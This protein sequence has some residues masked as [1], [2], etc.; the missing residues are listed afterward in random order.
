MKFKRIFSAFLAVALICSASSSASVLGTSF[1]NGYSIPIASETYFCNNTFLSDQSGVGL[2]TEN[3]I[4]YT[5]NPNVTPVVGYGKTV[6]GNLTKTLNEGNRLISEGKD[7]VGGINADYF[8]FQTGVPM[9]NLVV[10]GEVITKDSSAK[11]GFGV[12]ENGNGFMGES[13]ITATLIRNDNRT[14]NIECI[15]KYRQ[16]YAMY[17]LNSKFSDQTHNNT[18]GFDIII[19]PET[20]ELKIGETIKG[21]VTYALCYNGSIK[22]PEGALVL[23][24]D[25]NAPMFNDIADIAV[26]DEVEI[27][28]DAPT[29]PRW[30]TA[31]FGMGSTGE[32][33]LSGGVVTPG[34]AAGA[35]PR[36]AIGITSDGNIILY[37]IDGRQSG[38]SYGVKLSTLAERMKELGCVEAIN[39]DGGGSTTIVG[40]L[41]GDTS[42]TLL[43]KPSDGSSRAVSTSIFLQNNLSATGKIGQIQIYPAEASYVLKGS[44]VTL[45]AKGVDTGF[46]PLDISGKVSYS[47]QSGKESTITSGGVFKARDSGSVSVI[48]S[49]DGVS[50]THEVFCVESPTAI[51]VKDSNGNALSTLRVS[52]NSSLDLSAVASYG[53]HTLEAN[54]DCFNWSV[55][56][57]I[58]SID[59]NGVF[60]ASNTIG[61]SGV[62]T[63]SAGDTICEIPTFITVDGGEDEELLYS[64]IDAEIS[65]G[66]LSGTIENEYSVD[67]QYSKLKITADG[68]ALSPEYDGYSFSVALPENTEKVRITATNDLEYT[69]VWSKTQ[70]IGK[71]YENPFVDTDGNWAK[72]I[73]S[74]MY[75]KGLVSGEMTDKGLCYNP[76]KEM[77]RAEF[78]VLICNYLKIDP[79]SY[80]SITLPYADLGEIPAWSLNH[81]KALYSLGILKG[82]GEGANGIYAD[83]KTGVSRAEAVTII[84]R[85]LPNGLKKTEVS[86]IDIEDI[87]SWALDGFKILMADKTVSGYEDGSLKPLKKLTKAEA[88]KLLY[89][90]Y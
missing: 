26:G 74:Y 68:E 42:L 54:D 50:A 16:P 32:Y 67:T 77:T 2:Q 55:S 78:A 59:K 9:S 4:V 5:P 90:L 25:V 31:I 39:L 69:S 41:L 64:I 76:Q 66:I 81:F 65:N 56:G 46:H 28:I 22:I 37:T 61:S 70:D 84:A 63:V 33:I 79:A 71:I 7:I 87:P 24:V 38:Y 10:G 80:S 6:Y 44:S 53:Y 60:T 27:A 1:I 49:Y 19:E 88:A 58:G 15:N 13:Y 43:N 73:L 52:R 86:G 48:A 18:L 40:R 83:P 12:D 3:Y 75:S 34:L 85:L 47:V 35:N 11:Y 72:D 17:L 62:I 45:S 23:T 51:S 14:M 20:D 30:K 21:T 89:S 57:N 82:R 29:E 36:S 8:S